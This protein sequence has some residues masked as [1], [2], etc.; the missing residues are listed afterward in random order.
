MDFK[1]SWASLLSFLPRVRFKEHH[2]FMKPPEV[3]DS[4]WIFTVTEYGISSTPKSSC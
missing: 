1:I 2:P 3:K 4:A